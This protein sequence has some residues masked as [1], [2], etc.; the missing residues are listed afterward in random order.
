L[1]R[2]PVLGAVVA[3]SLLLGRFELL[4]LFLAIYAFT[5]G[6]EWLFASARIRAADDKV[7]ALQ[8]WIAEQGTPGVVRTAKPVLAESHRRP[9]AAA[10]WLSG[11]LRRFVSDPLW[12]LADRKIDDTNIRVGRH[13]QSRMERYEIHG[14][15][16]QRRPSAVAQQHAVHQAWQSTTV[17]QPAI[18]DELL[19]A[20]MYQAAAHVS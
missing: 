18:T 5:A 9:L 8:L 1:K 14:T 16:G 15:V 20:W 3:I 2:I 19:Y 7:Q 4:P 11:V 6:A 13:H 17:E 10:A 12:R